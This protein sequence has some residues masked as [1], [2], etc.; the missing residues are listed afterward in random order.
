MT[1]GQAVKKAYETRSWSEGYIVYKDGEYEVA[2]SGDD[3]ECAKENGWEFVGTGEKVV[4]RCADEDGYYTCGCYY[5]YRTADVKGI[6][7]ETGKY[8]LDNVSGLY[9]SW[10]GGDASKDYNTVDDFYDTEMHDY[11][12]N[13]DEVRDAMARWAA[14]HL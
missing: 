6:D 10:R 3:L 2:Y 1:Y 14:N 4:I 9:N 13:Y 7:A 5:F 11:V 8:I 12:Q